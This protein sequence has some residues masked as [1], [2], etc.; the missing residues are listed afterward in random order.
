M[1]AAAAGGGL[2]KAR[3]I[4]RKLLPV[5]RVLFLESNPGPVKYA[6]SRL[7]LI[8]NE[9]RPPLATVTAETAARIDRELEVLGLKLS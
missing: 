5:F 6:L 7:G 2:E 4:H 8:A 1:L 9:V 3:E